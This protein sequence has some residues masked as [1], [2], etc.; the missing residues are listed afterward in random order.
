MPD[1]WDSGPPLPPSGGPERDGPGRG[2]P[3]R[4]T[5]PSPPIDWPATG[6]SPDAAGPLAYGLERAYGPA[7]Q[8]DYG[9]LAGRTLT[10]A[11]PDE[12]FPT[13]ATPERQAV[14]DALAQILAPGAAGADH[15]DVQAALRGALADGM[16][17]ADRAAVGRAALDAAVARDPEALL[18]R[19]PEI[20]REHLAAW[21]ELAMTRTPQ[22]ILDRMEAMNEHRE[23]RA[24]DAFQDRL[25]T[26]DYAPAPNASLWAPLDVREVSGGVVNLDYY[27]VR[28]RLPEGTDPAVLLNHVRKNLDDF[29][30]T[31]RSAFS[32]Y[33]NQ[34]GG[35]DNVTRWAGDETR[36]HRTTRRAVSSTSTSRLPWWAACAYLPTT[37]LWP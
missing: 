27:A 30:D 23:A 29:V 33:P 28:V 32:A 17:Q 25:R 4:T 35:G 18:S 5:A 11:A 12:A 3:E 1:L 19:D 16:T 34:P 14:R 10:G 9:T 15:P 31:D 26:R 37:G 22:S 20:P 2:G 36:G 7:W 13:A 8:Q 24:Q 21:R 6:L